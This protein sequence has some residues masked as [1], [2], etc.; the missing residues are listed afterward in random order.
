MSLTISYKTKTNLIRKLL[1]QENIDELEKK[2]FFS[3]IFSS[4]NNYADIYFHTG[5]IDNES[6]EKIKNAKIVIVNSENLKH[7]VILQTNID[8]SKIHVI[9][10]SIDTIYDKP[11]TIKKNLCEKFDIDSKKKLIFFT[12]KNFEK[13]GIKEFIQI[14][15]SLT[16]DN[17][18]VLIAGDNREITT[19]KF[20][21]SKINMFEHITLIEEYENIDDLFL[22]SDIFILPSYNQSFASNVLK[23]MFCKC[24]VFVTSINHSNELVDVFATMDDPDDR[25]MG[26][27]VDALLSNNEDL[28]LIKKENRKKALQYTLENNL[29]RINEIINDI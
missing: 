4:S 21:M 26:F 13:S 6:L 10:P 12:A 3:K 22:A 8:S 14:I 20:K 18:H 16:N 25:S 29:E 11:K 15:A 2:S 24:A 5:S 1:E 23:A 7:K 28:K 27:K 9:Y 19:L 17:Y